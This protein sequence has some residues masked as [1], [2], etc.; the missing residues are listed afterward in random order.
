MAETMRH[1]SFRDRWRIRRDGRLIL[2][3]DVRL[4]GHIAA[5]LAKPALGNGAR[6]I[7]TIVHVAPD[8]GCKLDAVREVL[9]SAVCDGGAS[10]WDGMLVV[11]IA[12][13]EAHVV[14]ATVAGVLASLLPTVSPRIW[15]C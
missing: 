3:E 1:G 9:G 11:R 6:A 15:S 7:A 2:A 10:A 12:G 13:R 4:D 5:T 8:L 14:R